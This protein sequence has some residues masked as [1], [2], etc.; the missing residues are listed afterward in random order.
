MAGNVLIGHEDGETKNPIQY[1][2]LF[3]IHQMLTQKGGAKKK[4]CAN[5][6]TKPSEDAAYPE[7][8]KHFCS[9]MCVFDI[10]VRCNLFY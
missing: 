3:H 7:I 2:L 6:V 8:S 1:L 5:S 10:Q 9:G 4:K